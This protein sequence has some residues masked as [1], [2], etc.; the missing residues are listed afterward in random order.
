MDKMAILG[1]RRTPPIVLLTTLFFIFISSASA[2]ILGIDLGTE[3]IKAALVKPGIPLEI[4][5]T[6]DSRR[7][8]AATVAFK[9]A[10][11]ADPFPERVYGSD[12]VALA[13][14]FPDSV[15][16]NLK[17]LLGVT[18]GD[19][20][21]AEYK[22][23]RPMLELGI[24]QTRHTVNFRSGLFENP[25]T[26]LVEELLAMELQN[27]RVNAEVM[28]GKGAVVRDAVITV[29]AFY[30]IDEKRAVELAAELAGIKVVALLSDGLAVGLNY[31]TSRT[32][33]SINDGASPEAH[34]VFDMGAG[35]TTA[36]VVRFQGRTV[37]DVG[38][39]NKT[40]QE[41]AVLATA[42]DRT[43]GG[44]ALNTVIA[45][46]IVAELASSPKAKQVSLASASV[47]AH[48]RANARILKEAERVRQ[49]LSAN[50][51]TVAG[52][53]G[54]YED[55]DFRY[56]LSRSKF[57]G[58][59]TS[60]ADRVS[61]VIEKALANAR[62]S[63]AELDSVI[64]HGGVIRTPFVQKQ[65]E[66]AVGDAAKLRSNV[67]SDEAAVFGAAFKGAG[68]SASF[69]VKEIRTNDCSNY[70]VGMQ[71]EADGKGECPAASSR[72]RVLL[73]VLQIDRRGYSY[74]SHRPAS[75]RRFL[76]SR[77]KTLPLIFTKSFPPRTLPPILRRSL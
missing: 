20:R 26:F 23:R 5:L 50:T 58:M 27:I 35:S 51:E 41:V 42:W 10:G 7:K 46:D 25:E 17:P 45:D 72:R 32:F 6:K 4:V 15:F 49:V 69:R 8:E 37:K 52:F 38:K 57:E 31:A 76:S 43:L 29:P 63:M 24:D 16:P 18:E 71:W 14:R 53:E 68:M 13:A 54:I 60:F 3:Y 48:A 70:A 19:P 36:T 21:I 28:A 22:T 75:T 2:A 33:P 74:P 34:L 1:R 66:K 9:P 47:K 11:K 59:T 64:L 65:L 39:L 61:A 44:D 30:T 62:L 73:T 40:V 56:K 55:V 12:A 67:N 77:R